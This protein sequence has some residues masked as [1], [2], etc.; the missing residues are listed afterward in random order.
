MFKE[1]I[2]NLRAIMTVMETPEN[3]VV[4]KATGIKSVHDLKG[5]KVDLGAAGSSFWQAGEAI[6]KA[7]GI[8]TKDIKPTAMGGREGCDALLDKRLDAVMYIY[9]PPSPLFMELVELHDVNFISFDQNVLKDFVKEYPYYSL[10]TIEPNTYKKQDYPVYT[11]SQTSL[12]IVTEDEDPAFVKDLLKTF[13]DHKE[14][15]GKLDKVAAR[16]TLKNASAGAGIPY[17]AAAKQFYQ[18]HN[19]WIPKD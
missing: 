8:S 7:H 4:L 14:E 1:P 12:L 16:I 3:L 11:F 2:R 10:Y 18:S 15:V 9:Q 13:F 17:H 6:L 5:T 19:V